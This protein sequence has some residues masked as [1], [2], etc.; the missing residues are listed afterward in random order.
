MQESS[1]VSQVPV[2][3]LTTKKAI[4]AF[5]RYGLLQICELSETD[6]LETDSLETG[7]T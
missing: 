4:P 7:P 1:T 2:S 5:D 3:F 6:S